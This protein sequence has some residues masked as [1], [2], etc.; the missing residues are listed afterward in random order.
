MTARPVAL[1]LR[2]LGLGDFFTGLPAL[3]MLRRALPGHEIVLA[4]PATFG[5]LALLSGSVD[6]TIPG[7]ELS[8]LN[9]AP[10]RPDVAVDLH[11][12]GP[13]SQR[14]L[15]EHR[16]RRL[17]AFGGVDSG[18]GPRWRRDEHETRRWCRLVADSFGCGGDGWPPAAGALPVPAVDCASPGATIVHPGAA[19]RARQW[20][21]DRFVAVARALARAG[22]RVVVTGG[23]AD[24]ELAAQVAAGAGAQACTALSVAELCA[25]VSA[26]RLVVCGDT[27]IAHVATNYRTPS[28][29]L[30]GPVSPAVW[31]PPPDRR[32]R[33]L[34]HGAPSG[35]PIPGDPHGT[36]P[37]PRLLRISVAEV[38]SAVRDVDRGVR[39][40]GVA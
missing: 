36:E 28:V 32:H 10:E 12:N 18:G 15:L 3:A 21:P 16:P 6:R 37:D 30:F 34:W 31:G 24:G 25:V 29:V 2:A 1:V 17:V 7:H 20:P 38:L 4:T 40:A 27:G 26:A 19:A 39:L 33:A 22:H 5:A 14:L 35:S 13:A 9:A 11:G 8:P 23:P